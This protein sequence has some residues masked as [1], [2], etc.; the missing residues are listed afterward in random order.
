MNLSIELPRAAERDRER[1][2]A[3][4]KARLEAFLNQSRALTAAITAGSSRASISP[5]VMHRLIDEGREER[6]ADM[7]RAARGEA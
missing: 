3:F 5:Q 6:L 2:I 1:E 7:E 4:Q